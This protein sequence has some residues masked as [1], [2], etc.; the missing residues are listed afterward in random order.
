MGQV[1]APALVNPLSELWSTKVELLSGHTKCLTRRQLQGIGTTANASSRRHM[2][3]MTSNI[4]QKP[5]SCNQTQSILTTGVIWNTFFKKQKVVYEVWS[6]FP[7]FKQ[8]VLLFCVLS[9]SAIV[10]VTLISQYFVTLPP[11][12]QTQ[13]ERNATCPIVFV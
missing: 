10:N 3:K 7:E 9:D 11:H 1:H 6:I 13:S 8:I 2:A 4:S 5:V 12:T